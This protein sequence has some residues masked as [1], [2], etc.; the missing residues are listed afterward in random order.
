MKVLIVYQKGAKVLKLVKDTLRKHGIEFI[1]VERNKKNKTVFKG[2]DLVIAVGGDGTF[3]RTSHYIEHIPHLGVNSNPKLKEGFYTR[4]NGRDFVAKFERYL[5]GDYKTMELTRLH[6][7]VNG[8]LLPELAL[9][10]IYVGNEKAYRPSRYTLSC[11][12]RKEMQRSSGVIVSTGSGAHA[13]AKSAGGKDLKFGS[14]QVQCVVREQYKGKIYKGRMGNCLV[15]DK[16]KVKYTADNGVVVMDTLSVEY[17][18]KKNDV[19]EIKKGKN[20]KFICF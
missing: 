6:A 16:V 3:L 12:S 8:K 18:L 17:K 2:K 11:D 7:R 20:L 13:W 5:K 1:A 14:K 4:C 9:N 10:E 19:V 15:K